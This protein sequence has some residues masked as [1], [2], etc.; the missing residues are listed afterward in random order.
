MKRTAHRVLRR[1]L[2]HIER[3]IDG[4]GGD[5]GL[6]DNGLCAVQCAT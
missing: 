4:V 1:E 2:L 6:V 5:L 3:L